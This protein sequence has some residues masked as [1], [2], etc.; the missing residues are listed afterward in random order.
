MTPL[1]DPRHPWPTASRWV[2]GLSTG[3][4]L[5]ALLSTVIPGSGWLVVISGLVA[6]FMIVVLQAVSDR[7]YLNLLSY[8]YQQLQQEKADL[9]FNYQQQ[10]VQ[11]RL[12]LDITLNIRQSLNL[13][14][15]MET[16]VSE[17]R[18]LL[19]VNRVMVYQFEANWQG[20]IVAES[21]SDPDLSLME[22][23]IED[24]CF[25]NHW[26]R[27]YREGYIHRVDH[28]D[29]ADLD[30]CYR[31]LLESMKVQ[32]NLVLPI[33]HDKTLWGLLAVHHCTQPRTWRDSEVVLL[34]QVAEQF[35]IAIAQAQLIKNLQ[36][37]NQQLQD[38]VRLDGLTQIANR[39]RFDEYLRDAWNW[40]SR[41][42]TPLALLLID[43]DYFKSYNDYYGHLAGDEVLRRIGLLLNASV[44]RST[45]L[46]ARYGGEEF[47]AL[48]PSTTVEGALAVAQRLRSDLARVKLRHERSAVSD[49]VTVSI[50]VAVITPS[51]EVT[52]IALIRR[53]DKALYAAKA[54]GRN[55]VQVAGQS[56]EVI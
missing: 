9:A 23:H 47:V 10:L 49:R 13:S 4:L 52:S 31:G 37:A 34:S 55:C 12:L 8:H 6:G 40:G 56:S 46:V 45:D 27:Q 38:Q 24:N 35:S 54:A 30:P 36:V 48:L 20:R 3:L 1:D 41:D 18:N 15:V 26:D 11:E 53:A 33:R 19:R 17:V 21:V 2:A 51:P 14:Q 32:S 43:V 42:Q 22:F 16:T 50:G 29:T 5:A 7:R 39:R 25:D 44:L 28:I